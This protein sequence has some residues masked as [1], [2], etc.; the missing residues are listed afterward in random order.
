MCQLQL[1]KSR[2][3]KKKILISVR[4]LNR[5]LY[6]PRAC[7]DLRWSKAVVITPTG[8][9]YI[10]PK[11]VVLSILVQRSRT[12]KIFFWNFMH[13]LW[14]VNDFNFFVLLEINFDDHKT[15]ASFL[16]YCP[17]ELWCDALEQRDVAS[18]WPTLVQR[19]R[20]ACCREAF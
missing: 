4:L 13:I 20:A 11:N 1:R 18:R 5:F 3:R 12:D 15:V 14:H 19:S 10:L 17:F 7:L 9:K 2:K 16:V 8:T 6:I